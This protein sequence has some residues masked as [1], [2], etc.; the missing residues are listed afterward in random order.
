[1][2]NI[3]VYLNVSHKPL[4]TKM[5]IFVSHAISDQTFIHG[6]K[7]KLEPF[8]ITLFVAEHYQE[9]QYSITEKIETMIR[10]C[11]VAL[12]LLTDKGFN[13]NFV[14][15]EIGYIK[16]CNK[17]S[18]KVVQ[19]GIE[20]KLTGFIYGHDYLS[21]DPDQPEKTLEK[22]KAILLQY[23]NIENERKSKE[24][25]IGLGILAGIIVLG[26]SS[27]DN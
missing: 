23:W 14:Q 3:Y 2:Y 15:Q 9:L 4:I 17:P 19:V 27:G 12:I 26:L 18:L 7:N 22:I 16:S 8:G 10:Q 21:H 1:M 13:S 6:L 20:N 24:T 11:D 5:K 25:K